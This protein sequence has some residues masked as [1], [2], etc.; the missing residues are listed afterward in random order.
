M[1]AQATNE[2]WEDITRATVLRGVGEAYSSE[3]AG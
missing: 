3:E 1:D 2:P